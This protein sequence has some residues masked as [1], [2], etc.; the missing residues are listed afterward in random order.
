M[1]KLNVINNAEIH[2]V[3]N[4]TS[5]SGQVT[6]WANWVVLIGLETNYFKDLEFG[7]TRLAVAAGL[8]LQIE[9]SFRFE[10]QIVRR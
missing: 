9:P 5:V 6:S 4:Y 8:S 1:W 2:I 3:P 10:Y 7:Q